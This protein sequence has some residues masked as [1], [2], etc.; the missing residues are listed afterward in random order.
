MLGRRKPL[1]VTSKDEILRA[2]LA[3]KRRIVARSGGG[4]PKRVL[5]RTLLG[6]PT[7]YRVRI[8]GRLGEVKRALSARFWSKGGRESAR[9]RKMESARLFEK[10]VPVQ[11]QAL[12]ERAVQVLE[13]GGFLAERL[14]PDPARPG[15]VISF[16]A[17]HT[18]HELETRYPRRFKRIATPETAEK[19]AD[20][21]G[22]LWKNGLTH[23]DTHTA[24]TIYFKG[25][26]GL[27]DWASLRTFEFPGPREYY[28]TLL[29]LFGDLYL[30][31]HTLEAFARSNP[32]AW[33]GKE[34][35]YAALYRRAL[36]HLPLQP[37]AL[38]KAMEAITM[39]KFWTPVAYLWY[40]M[41]TI[42]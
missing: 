20:L 40:Q 28:P 24:N 27:V 14:V 39:V 18:L 33:A 1:R 25:K 31:G 35:K 16:R 12:V 32:A 10:R 41:S 42:L 22:T 36:G 34:Q 38:D 5:R 15:R 30:L 23:R 37:E 26:V 17:G 21:L 9:L 2:A 7:A 4:H 19:I 11:T 13:R 29:R 3:G 8:R 6:K